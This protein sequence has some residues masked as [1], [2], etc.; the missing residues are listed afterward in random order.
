MVG[1]IRLPPPKNSGVARGAGQSWG[2]VPDWKSA[3]RVGPLRA[4]RIG[5]VLQERV[6]RRSSWGE[7][8][9]DRSRERPSAVV[10][11]RG[12]GKESVRCRNGP[13]YGPGY[14]QQKVPG[15]WGGSRGLFGGW[16]ACCVTANAPSAERATGVGPG[17]RQGGWDGISRASGIASRAPA[18][19]LCSAI[20]ETASRAARAARGMEMPNPYI[21]HTGE[22]EGARVREKGMSS[23][24]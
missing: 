5:A 22:A 24:I 10:G 21:A 19:S 11:R 18:C 2:T 7:P 6:R 13:S 17:F 9:R 12:D 15:I 14:R 20:A 16:R 4:F 1:A 23:A 8:M 3:A